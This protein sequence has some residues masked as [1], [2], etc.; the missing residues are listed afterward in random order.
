MEK[1]F[2]DLLIESINNEIIN[3]IKNSNLTQKEIGDALGISQAGVSHIL[4]GK[5]QINLENFINIASILNLNPKDILTSAEKNIIGKKILTKSE[6]SVIF[7]SKFHF[8][9]YFSAVKPIPKDFLI[10][11]IF[12]KDKMTMAIADLLNAN[13]LH[14][15]KNHYYIDESNYI[16]SPSSKNGVYLEYKRF[17]EIIDF[18]QE[19]WL[20]NIDNSEYREDRF[21]SMYLE[22]LTG[23]Q[24]KEIKSILYMAYQ[25]I[26]EYSKLNKITKISENNETILAVFSLFASKVEWNKK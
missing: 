11:K 3:G 17:F 25:K 12:P 9:I 19:V 20:Q 18:F 21:N 8:F 7:K 15:S 23:Q 24:F 13:L 16:F 6:E 4:T 22:H 14:E 2:N 1:K 26:S 5:T 10:S